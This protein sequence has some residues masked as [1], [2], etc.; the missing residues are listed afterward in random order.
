MEILEMSKFDSLKEIYSDK[1]IELLKV[2]SEQSKMVFED[3]VSKL[4]SSDLVKKDEEFIATYPIARVLMG[5]ADPASY[6]LTY[7]FL[8]S[9]IPADYP[10][11]P[12]YYISK[13]E[14]SILASF[15]KQEFID[16]IE[17]NKNKIIR[18]KIGSDI[19][20]I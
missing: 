15:T 3:I 9:G 18:K 20:V 13:S 7:Y 14:G 16:S 6:V 8:T 4:P 1:Y 17:K 11:Q 2:I 10:E 19:Y 12:R 5:I